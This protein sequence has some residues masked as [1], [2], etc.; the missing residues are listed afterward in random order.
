MRLSRKGIFDPATLAQRLEAANNPVRVFRD[1]LLECREKLAEHH[2]AGAPATD[3]VT[4]HAWLVDQVLLLAWQE[5]SKA[6]EPRG[7]MSLVAVGGYG[8]GEL[9]P[10]S[11]VDLLVLLAKNTNPNTLDFVEKLVRFLWDIGLEV[12][13]SVRTIKECVKE[14]RNDITVA[15]NL[16]E[17]RL[18]LGDPPLYAEL[19]ERIRPPKIWPAR[20][21]FEAKWREQIERHAR[22]HDTAYNLEPHVKEGPGGLRDI[23]MIGWVAQRYFGTGDLKELVAHEFLTLEEHRTLIRGRNF[24]WRLRN[25][26]HFTAKRREDRLLF[27]YQREIAE[28]FGYQDRAGHL[29]VEQLMKRYYRTVKDLRLLNEILLQHFQEAILSPGR[30][31]LDRINRRFRSRDGF[32]EVTNDNVFERYP[33]ALLEAFLILQ[34][35]ED[36]RGIRAA[37]IR[38]IR[39]NLHRI[40]QD[41]RQDIRSR[42]LFMEILRAPGG[43]THALREMN[44][45]GIL[46]A[47][48][49]AFGQVVGQM[50]H[51]LFHV[52]TVDA[53]LLF[54]V[55]NLRRLAIDRHKDELPL[56]RQIMARLFKRHRLYLAGLFHDIAKGRGGDHSELG[57]QDAFDFCKRHD[58]SD[59]DAHFVAWL[60]RHHL[61]MSWVAQRKDISDPQVIHE[62]ARIVGDQEH[63]DNLYLLTVA[64]IRGTSPKVWNEWKGQLLSE[65]YGA[66]TR[67]LNRGITAPLDLEMRLEELKREV[68]RELEASPDG[69][70]ATEKLWQLLSN[71][72]LLRHSPQTLAWHAQ[73]LNT[74]AVT[75]LP[76]VAGRHQRESGTSHYL[77]LAP[78]A[79]P[80]LSSITAGFDR[81]NLN[82][83]DARVHPLRS[84]LVMMLFV[85]LDEHFPEEKG[86]GRIDAQVSSLREQL[87]DPKPG[88]DPRRSHLSRALKHFPIPTSVIFSEAPGENYTI[89]EVVAQDRPG[90]LHQVANAFLHCKVRLVT[91]KVSTFGE[92]AEDIFC[93]TDRDNQ[94]L[95]DDAQRDCVA[96]HVYQ[97]LPNAE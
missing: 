66:T 8:R 23:Q 61:T 57:E 40:G 64:D 25:A 47:Y 45:Y 26:L 96:Q 94:P 19:E 21:F 34:Q 5:V 75:D 84:G 14:A 20:R 43:Q 13:H 15:T 41:F 9:H 90:L 38:L 65:L 22:F 91:A 44:A 88:R 30:K 18:I 63:L 51:D 85:V 36:L 58:M 71:D 7:R 82:I 37:T 81:L 32:L 77:I 86:E 54:V 73:C 24:L 62:F 35:N 29:A 53:H 3:I 97:S 89:M 79:E 93:V 72:Y 50:Q 70:T 12:G 80:L 68:F 78:D 46:G 67:A 6:I 17:S 16:M 52:Y 49:P 33:F 69:K 11:D 48:I 95:S 59:Y 55:R 4:V 92:R 76:L 60:V 42:T 74:A 27:D 56:A 10:Y 28:D 87:L 1:T 2:H 31:R 39:A 83:V